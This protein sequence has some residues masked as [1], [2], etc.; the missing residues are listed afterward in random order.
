MFLRHSKV[1]IS[2]RNYELDKK[3]KV[4]N[5]EGNECDAIASTKGEAN[6]DRKILPVKGEKEK[7]AWRP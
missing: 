2:L 4:R 5:G 6:Q 7:E 3:L 1:G